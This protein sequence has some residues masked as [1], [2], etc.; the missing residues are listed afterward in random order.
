ML[1]AD[2][3]FIHAW[4]RS[5]STYIWSKLRDNEALRCYYEPLHEELAEINP[6]DLG[7]PNIELSSLV[8]HPIPKKHYYFEYAE[9]LRSN[10]LRYCSELAYDQYLL[11]PGQA[12]D[13]L[14]IYLDGLIS[15]ASAAG[16]RPVLC[17]CRSQMRSAWMK[18]NFGG[19]HIAQIRNPADQWSSFGVT[20][21]FTE[22]LI[23]IG[24]KLRNL[25]PLAFV[26]ITPFE[27]LARDLSKRPSI[28]AEMIY[29]FFLSKT[30]ILGVYLVIWIASA[31]QA[32]SCCDLLLDIDLLSNDAQYR[33]IA[34]QWFESIGCPTDFYD[35]SIPTSSNLNSES[36]G[37]TVEEATCAIR[38]GA[39]SLVVTDPKTIEKRLPLLSPLSRSVLSMALGG[40]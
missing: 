24:L 14:G 34:S 4:W 37:R 2:I 40:E 13:K 38:S 26:H 36:F 18:E 25:H 17:F 12:E 19:T 27:R 5:G 33:N 8:R 30:D 11:L 3:I 6:N 7:T 16:K 32:I 39:S 31:L 29:K 10:S 20:P 35:C 28:P 15:A 21:Y 1:R 22:R 23:T 9:L